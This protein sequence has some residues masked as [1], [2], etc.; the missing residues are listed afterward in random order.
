MY[1]LIYFLFWIPATPL[2]QSPSYIFQIDQSQLLGILNRSKNTAVNKGAAKL[3]LNENN[4]PNVWS[5][6]VPGLI[7]GQLALILVTL[8][9]APLLAMW[10]YSTSLESSEPLLTYL[11][12]FRIA[13]LLRYN[14][15]I[16]C[17]PSFISAYVKGLCIFFVKSVENLP[18][19]W[20]CQPKSRIFL[21]VIVLLNR[22]K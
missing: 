12:P 8:N 16:L 19:N 11:I 10:T 22:S 21:I 18:R 17:T 15:W 5:L 1:F 13:L 20:P 6:G 9:F 2:S 4:L 14:C 3:R 7:P